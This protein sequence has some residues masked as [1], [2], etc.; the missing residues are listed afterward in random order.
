MRGLPAQSAPPTA[1]SLKPPPASLLSR[2][3]PRSNHLL[4]SL[5]KLYLCSLANA[6]QFSRPDRAAAAQ[7][8][9]PAVTLIQLGAALLP[10]AAVYRLERSGRRWVWAA[11]ERACLP[12]AARRRLLAD[13]A[14]PLHAPP[15]LL[16]QGVCAQAAAAAA[17]PGRRNAR[18]RGRRRRERQVKHACASDWARQPCRRRPRPS[19]TVEILS[20]S[21][22]L[23]LWI[24]ALP[25]W[26]VAPSGLHVAPPAN[27]C[28]PQRYLLSSGAIHRRRRRRRRPEGRPAMLSMLQ[29][30]ASA[31]LRSS[32]DA[33]L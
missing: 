22:C 25:T 10:S 33:R 6:F 12:P 4:V 26:C 18:R 16:L 27:A 13:A 11:V 1:V 21:C 24:N 5:A 30:Q 17:H 28:C 2:A 9:L 29:A 19:S 14:T 15:L 20:L 7:L 32:H 31:E 3:P 8:S 23:P